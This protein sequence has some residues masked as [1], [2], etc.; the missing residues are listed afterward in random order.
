MSG[1]SSASREN[2]DKR[3]SRRQNLACFRATSPIHRGLGMAADSEAPRSPRKTT[4]CSR[5]SPALASVPLLPRILATSRSFASQSAGPGAAGQVMPRPAFPAPFPSPVPRFQ[6]PGVPRA[7]P[8]RVQ[9]LAPGAL[10]L[11]SPDGSALPPQAP[12]PAFPASSCSSGVSAAHHFAIRYLI[13]SALDSAL[14][15]SHPI[16]AT[17]STARGSVASFLPQSTGKTSPSAYSRK[18]SI[19]L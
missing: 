18:L 15:Q 13:T 14:L 10:S 3:L 12:P 4:P 11:P 1:C 17:T 7:P 2:L 16:V 19:P 6:P 8:A 9:L 5:Q